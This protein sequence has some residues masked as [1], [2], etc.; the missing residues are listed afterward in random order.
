MWK[1]AKSIFPLEQLYV[2]VSEV[3]IRIRGRLNS[4]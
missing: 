4:A 2:A 1:I 3:T